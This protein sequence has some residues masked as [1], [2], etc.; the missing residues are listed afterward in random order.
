MTQ[1]DWQ[2]RLTGRVAD[3]VRRLREERGMT[4]QEV[5]DA[6]AALG[7]RMPRSVIANLENGRR[8]GID[9]TELLVLA[10]VLDVPPVALLVP[11][12]QVSSVELLPGRDMPT[13]EALEW[14]SGEL[15]LG[16]EPEEDTL[17]ERYDQLRRHAQGVRNVL[18]A[19]KTADE[20]RRALTLIR[21]PK[22]RAAQEDWVGKMDMYTS[23]TVHDLQDYRAAMR[24]RGITPPDLPEEL[25]HLD[26]IQTE[27]GWVPI[28]EGP[29][30]DES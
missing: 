21:D 28:D 14:V 6:C 22:Q 29:K 9:L 15:P 27:D 10:K 24:A 19:T 5:A 7:H 18:L 26:L 11:A 20:Y 2:A 17:E 3:T 1:I 12:G 4:A 16:T 13:D 30:P 23:Q 25:D 8:S